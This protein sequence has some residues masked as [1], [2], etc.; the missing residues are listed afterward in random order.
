L[1][2]INGRDMHRGRETK[3][4]QTGVRARI[5]SLQCKQGGDLHSEIMQGTGTQDETSEL[6]RSPQTVRVPGRGG[7]GFWGKTRNGKI[8]RMTKKKIGAT[9]HQKER[10]R[11]SDS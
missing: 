3:K 6:R 7:G 10:R 11:I 5:K 8:W 1:K 2:E 9:K 4:L